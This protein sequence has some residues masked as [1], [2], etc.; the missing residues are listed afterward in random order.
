MQNERAHQLHHCESEQTRYTQGTQ[1]C[2]SVRRSSVNKQATRRT[3]STAQLY[4]ELAWVYKLHAEQTHLYIYTESKR[5]HTSYTQNTHKC[6][7]DQKASVSWLVAARITEYKSALGERKL[8]KQHA[9]QTQIHTYAELTSNK[10]SID[11]LPNCAEIECELWSFTH[12]KF[13][14]HMLK[15]ASDTQNKTQ[16]YNFASHRTSTTA[17]QYE[18]RTWA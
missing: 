13:L 5:K 16:M 8:K 11:Q 2:T 18:E 14:K 12:N 4:W 10:Q 6:T 9:K 15:R 17:R 7:T 1:Y 3:S